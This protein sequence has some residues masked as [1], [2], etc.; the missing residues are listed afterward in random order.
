MA[1]IL[2][3]LGDT[4]RSKAEYSKLER[5]LSTEIGAEYMKPEVTMKLAEAGLVGGANL[6]DKIG[7]EVTERGMVKKHEA[8][9]EDAAEAELAA[10]LKLSRDP[11][12]QTMDFG[13][14]RGELQHLRQREEGEAFRSQGHLDETIAA[15]LDDPNVPEANKELLLKRYGEREDEGFRGMLDGI[16]G[17]S[18]ERRKAAG[19]LYKDD[20]AEQL[21]GANTIERQQAAVKDLFALT[22]GLAGYKDLADVMTGE[23]REKERHAMLDLM[24]EIPKPE[25]PRRGQIDPRM[26]SIDVDLESKRLSELRKESK[27]FLDIASN[28]G[29]SVRFYTS[30]QL[31]DWGVESSYIDKFIIKEEGANKGKIPI[32]VIPGH[33]DLFSR[34]SKGGPTGTGTAEKKKLL[35]RGA[36][37]YEHAVA[38]RD[39]YQGVYTGATEAEEAY[40]PHSYPGARNMPKADYD[41]QRPYRIKLGKDLSRL[42]GDF[43]AIGHSPGS[44]R[45]SSGGQPAGG[46]AWSKYN[47]GRNKGEEGEETETQ[48]A[49]VLKHPK[50]PNKPTE[51]K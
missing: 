17:P 32:A 5:G 37:E 41:E 51:K 46:G 8:Q 1:R 19:V 39:K 23:S 29:G 15:I 27:R 18:K 30:D 49:T 7:Q 9:A 28:R 43:D 35:L 16:F 10:G 40:S 47:E 33:E 21:A 2:P 44:D 26:I 4:F 45:G 13:G 6:V 20:V 42:Q 14:R 25:R 48:E 36:K 34:A 38:N 12:Q 50:K 3:T 24:P 22:R 11:G 31:K